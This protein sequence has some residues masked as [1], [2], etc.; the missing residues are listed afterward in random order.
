MNKE[1][2]IEIFNSMGL[3]VSN[4]KENEMIK[5]YIHDSLA[6]VSF[7]VFIEDTFQIE[8]DAKYFTKDFYETSFL[9]LEKIICDAQQNSVQGE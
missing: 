2:I 5:E 4:Y 7:M 9:E 3:Q 8:I 6:L 1:K